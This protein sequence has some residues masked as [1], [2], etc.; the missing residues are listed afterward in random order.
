MAAR[1]ARSGI[2]NAEG[3]RVYLCQ[4]SDESTDAGASIVQTHEP[5]AASQQ[6]L[7][8]PTD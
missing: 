8:M 6:W 5:A 2:G 4:L 7:L 1:T 3:D